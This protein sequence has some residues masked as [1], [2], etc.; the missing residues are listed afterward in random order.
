MEAVKRGGDR[1]KL[2]EVIRQASMEATAKMKAGE[3]CDLLGRL[4]AEP[5]F[6]LTEDEIKEIMRPELYTGRC[7]E[8]VDRYLAKVRPL[9]EGIAEGSSEINV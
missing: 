1:Q 2:H 7:A 4:S 6:A 9:I 5:Q 3:D 8:Q